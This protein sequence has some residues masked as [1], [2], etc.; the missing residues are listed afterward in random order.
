MNIHEYKIGNNQ[1][2][3]KQAKKSVWFYV[4][5][6]KGLVNKCQQGLVAEL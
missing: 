1:L 2:G 4:E 6:Y 3:S 5:E